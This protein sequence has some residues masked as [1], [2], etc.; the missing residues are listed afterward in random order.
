M[1]KKYNEVKELE[2]PTL[3][4]SKKFAE[5]EILKKIEEKKENEILP[6][7]SH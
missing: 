6:N 3:G 2:N 5:E 4:I 7:K 1:I